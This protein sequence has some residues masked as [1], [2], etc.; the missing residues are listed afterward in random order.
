GRFL[1]FGRACRRHRLHLLPYQAGVSRPGVAAQCRARPAREIRVNLLTLDLAVATQILMQLAV[2]DIGQVTD[3][4]GLA[5]GE[6]ADTDGARGSGEPNTR[7]SP[8][9][10][11]QA[12]PSPRPDGRR[13]RTGVVQYAR[14]R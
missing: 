9:G 7:M 10:D 6:P 1:Q 13:L 8:T 2:T 14:A 3:I 12:A 4:Q 5:A 11:S